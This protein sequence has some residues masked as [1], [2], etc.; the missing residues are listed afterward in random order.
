M[1][2]F[3]Q[4]PILHGLC[5]YGFIARALIQELCAGDASRLK[6]LS[7]QFRKPVWPGEVIRTVGY[8]LGDG[9]V[10][11]Q[12]FA[13]GREDPVITSAYAEI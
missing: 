11:L 5:T 12:A 3:E 9:R 2:G 6:R 10:A 4:G 13:G 1:A 7:A 8:E